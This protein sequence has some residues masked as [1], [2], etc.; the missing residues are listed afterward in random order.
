M[1][2]GPEGPEFLKVKSTE[3]SAE[4][5]LRLLNDR[6][7]YPLFICQLQTKNDFGAYSFIDPSGALHRQ[8]KDHRSC[9]RYFLKQLFEDASLHA[10]DGAGCFEVFPLPTL[11]GKENDVISGWISHYYSRA[12]DLFRALTN[13][14]LQAI[15]LFNKRRRDSAEDEHG[16]ALPVYRYDLTCSLLIIQSI[17]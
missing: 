16:N 7:N 13:R 12:N 3:I 6:S 10:V 9:G 1:K 17:E 5:L 4:A 2:S 15:G 8:A 11:R 14:P